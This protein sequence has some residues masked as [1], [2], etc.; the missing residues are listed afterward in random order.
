MTEIESFEAEA[1]FSDLL[2][3]VRNEGEGF[4]VIAGGEPVATICPFAEKPK[5]KAENGEAQIGEFVESDVR[6]KTVHKA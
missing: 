3:R 6:W 5:H 1:H 2:R 4:I